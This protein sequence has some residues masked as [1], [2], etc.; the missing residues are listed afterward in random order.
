M[1]GTTVRI[2]IKRQG[3]WPPFAEPLLHVMKGVF[4][5]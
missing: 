5:Y 4:V 3:Q 1:V 2:I